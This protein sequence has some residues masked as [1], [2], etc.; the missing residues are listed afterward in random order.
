MADKLVE[1]LEAAGILPEDGIPLER[2]A[3]V[4]ATLTAS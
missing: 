3:E 2:Y 1:L 4:L